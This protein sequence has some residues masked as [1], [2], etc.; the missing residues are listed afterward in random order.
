[1]DTAET[2]PSGS[3]PVDRRDGAA[4]LLALALLVAAHFLVDL[5]ASTVN[6]LW[7]ALERHL[8]ME[9]GGALWVFVAWSVATSFSQLA[10]GVWA[11]R[12]WAR[13]LLWAGPGVGI[14]CLSSLG[15][16]G[17]TGA[18]AAILVCGGLGVAAFHPEAA[19][20]AGAILPSHR[21][22][23][24]AIFSL[25]GY[26]GQAIGPY[27]SGALT[28]HWG[29]A[30][31]LWGIAWGGAALLGLAMAW[32]WSPARFI[33]PQPG[34]NRRETSTPHA[35][36]RVA[37]LLVVSS[38]RVVPTIGVLL[39]LAYVLESQH[40][41]RST[42]GGVQSAF[43]AGIGAGSMICAL[44]SSPRW[45]WHALWL[46][47]VAASP[48]LA[49]LY[50]LEGEWLLLA[51]GLSGFLHGVGMPVFVSYGQQYLPAGE[52]V[53][54]SI[55]LGVSW[56]IAGGL[57]AGSLSYCQ[58]ADMLHHS[59]LFFAVISAISGLMC[60]GLPSV[61]GARDEKSRGKPI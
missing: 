13:W 51:V 45:E 60:L 25:S 2:I 5:F 24:M 32:C 22:R 35:L 50:F 7:P 1:M 6:P 3:W 61:A 31:L 26:L 15:L 58:K 17:S 10:F 19:A 21:S 41:A 47:P 59:F 29:L 27:Y 16:A 56:G 12:G 38:L 40:V 28:E 4:A 11:D 18:T 54:S 49:C 46:M 43:M 34:S 48:V 36:R 42:I 30:G 55:T 39:A 23:A 14:L 8:A 37:V 20:T 44:F 57:V 9:S 52:R 33:T 53:A